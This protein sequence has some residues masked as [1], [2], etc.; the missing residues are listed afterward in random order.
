VVELP[1]RPELRVDQVAETPPPE[2]TPVP[3]DADVILPVPGPGG[4]E[5]NDWDTL[6][7]ALPFKGVSRE[8][9]S[10][11]TL[12]TCEGER[13]RLL[14]ESAQT[15]LLSER[16][17]NGVRQVFE[18]FL[19]RRVRLEFEPDELGERT[20][21]A[22][23]AAREAERQRQA[24]ISIEHDPMVEELKQRFGAVIRDGSIKPLD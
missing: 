13:L 23:R 16:T 21:A 6:F 10:H 1:T 17:E 9:V 2:E 20:P 7:Q 18:S 24:E 5:D 14:V 12:A 3:V 19:G 4:L 22:R 11:C 8:L 15:H